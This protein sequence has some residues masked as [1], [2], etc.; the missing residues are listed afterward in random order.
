MS[1]CVVL[2]KAHLNVDVIEEK[3]KKPEPN[4]SD[5]N[6]SCITKKCICTFVSLF[7]ARIEFNFLPLLIK[8]SIFQLRN[9]AWVTWFFIQLVCGF[10]SFVCS[11]NMPRLYTSVLLYQ[12]VQS[13]AHI[14]LKRKLFVLI[15]SIFQQKNEPKRNN[16]L[17]DK[18]MWMI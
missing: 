3:V 16:C 4:A 10:W 15:F 5:L 7:N 17:T 1:V 2:K 6:L 9:H 14:W 13:T 12:N 11:M 18:R 8:S